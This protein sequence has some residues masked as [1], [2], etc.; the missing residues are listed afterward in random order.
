[1]G[2]IPCSSKQPNSPSG[3]TVWVDT[4]STLFRDPSISTKATWL[5]YFR[6]DASTDL[7]EKYTRTTFARTS[8]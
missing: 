4:R 6:L 5:R 7:V 8:V 2:K 1:M 3:I